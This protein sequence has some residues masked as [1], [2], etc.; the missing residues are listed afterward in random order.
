M[1]KEP[2]EKET[3]EENRNGKIS[4]NREQDKEV[5]INSRRCILRFVQRMEKGHIFFEDMTEEAA[6]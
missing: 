5:K 1:E 4:G 3:M 6:R 2:E